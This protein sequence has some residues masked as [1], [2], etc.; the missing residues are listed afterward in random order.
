MAAPM[1]ATAARDT[2]VTVRRLEASCSTATGCL[3]PCASFSGASATCGPHLSAQSQHFPRRQSAQQRA[4]ASTT[5][6]RLSRDCPF[7]FRL[8]SWTC[9]INYRLFSCERSAA[10]SRGPISPTHWIR[11]A[12]P[13]G[14]GTGQVVG[15]RAGRSSSGCKAQEP[16]T[17][18]GSVMPLPGALQ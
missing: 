16:K 13:M 4:I 9:M 3:S 11:T 5:Q 14:R 6:R 15:S 10:C 17:C 7:K 8:K 2:T 1:I 18:L 12:N